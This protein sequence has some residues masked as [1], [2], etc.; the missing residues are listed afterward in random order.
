[1][2]IAFQLKRYWYL[3]KRMHFG[4]SSFQTKKVWIIFIF[5]M[6]FFE[7]C[8]QSLDGRVVKRTPRINLL[9]ATSRASLM[10]VHV[11]LPISRFLQINHKLLLTSMN[12]I[13]ILFLYQIKQ[14]LKYIQKIISDEELTFLEL[15]KVIITF[16]ATIKSRSEYISVSVWRS[17]GIYITP[18]GPV[19]HDTWQW[20]CK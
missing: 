11:P 6:Q 10:W 5:S 19:T 16:L 15:E 4:I 9:L 3:N 2:N 13:Q 17:C 18:V 20:Y 12:K 1:M 7:Y 14:K 8:N